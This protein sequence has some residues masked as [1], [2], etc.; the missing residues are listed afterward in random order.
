MDKRSLIFVILLTI[1]L[2]FVNNFWFSGNKPVPTKP[3]Q[4]ATKTIQERAAQGPTSPVVPPLP[5]ENEKFYVIENAYQQLVFSSVGGALVEINLPL[6]SE[7][8]TKSVIQPVNFDREMLEFHPNNDYFPGGPY[9]KAGNNGLETVQKTSLGGYYPLL[10]RTIIDPNGRAYSKSSP[11]FY[12]LTLTGDDPSLPLEIYKLKKL[13]KNAIE[14][15]LVQG[16]RR[17]VKTYAFADN[18]EKAPY[19][20]SLDVKV[21]GDARG[22]SIK[23]GVPEVELISGNPA[24]SLQYL[25][26]KSHKPKVEQLSLPKASTTINSVLPNWISNSNGFLGLIIDPLTDI[27]P[28]ITTNL[29]SGVLDASRIVLIDSEYNRYP[30]EKYPGYEMSLPLLNANQTTK[31]RIYAGPYQKEILSLVDQYYTDPVTGYNP[32]Y[33]LALSFHGWF[34]FISEPFAKFLFMLMNFFH[35]LTSSWGFSIILLTVALR[36]M[37]YPLNAW[38]IKS[39]AKMQ[40]V[41]PKVS[42]I[43]EKYKKDPKR[44]QMEIMTLYREEKVNPLT[45]CFPIL[46]QIPFL[47]GMFDLLKSTF[48][49]RGVSFIPGWINN[50]TSPDVLFSW[51]YP[52]IFFGTD[53]HLLPFILGAAMYFQQKFSSTAPK[54]K[55]LMTDQQK[56]QKMMSNIMSI[57]FTVM[58]YHFPSG[59]NLYWLS[60]MLLGIL[61]QWYTAKRMKTHPIVTKM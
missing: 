32:Q 14:F 61:Q 31:F 17:I 30:A 13:E 20:F 24:P 29:V 39:M 12:A 15:E 9:V 28:G 42:A 27:S 45:G 58:F 44:A 34:T 60:S 2:Y 18:P 53:F 6:R 11:Q 55:K 37:L 25:M 51:N 50:L 43:Q 36:I 54:D 21:E 57:V 52:I 33:I 48:E 3:T 59:L 4:G 8:N 10:R 35:Y 16:N 22:L 19:T 49:L 5:P 46:I 41:S 7:Q 56:Q 38:S 23:S 47:I 40:Q 1:T 26:V